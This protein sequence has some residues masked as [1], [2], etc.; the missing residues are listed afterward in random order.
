MPWVIHARLRE[1]KV[2]D[3]K[4]GEVYCNPGY[5]LDGSTLVLQ[6]DEG[7]WRYPNGD[8]GPRDHIDTL[9]PSSHTPSRGPYFHDRCT[10]PAVVVLLRWES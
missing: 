1:C 7:T 10:L 4:P 2:C 5:P 8:L 3:V 6:G 9:V